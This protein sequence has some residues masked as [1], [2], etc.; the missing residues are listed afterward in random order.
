[1]KNLKTII[2]ILSTIF[3]LWVSIAQNNC[4]NSRFRIIWESEIKT[5]QVSEYTISDS[6][7]LSDTNNIK[8]NYTLWKENQR[9]ESAQW[10]KF[11]YNFEKEWEYFLKARFSIDWCTYNLEKKLDVFYKSILYIWYD[12]KEFEIWYENNF[13]N[14]AILFNKIIVSNNI[15]SENEIKNKILE[16]QNIIKNVNSIIINNKESD[17][18]FQ[19]LSKLSKSENIDLSNKE[20]FVINSTNKHFMKRILSKYIVN[21]KNKSTYLISEKNILNLLS[22]LS[23]WKNVLEESL[24]EISPLWFQE[25]SWRFF[26]SYLIDI[27]IANDFPINLIWFFLTITL[28][29]LFITWF[30]Q[31]IGFSVFWTFSPLLFG[32]SIAVLWTQASIIFFIIAFIA[33][34]LTRLITKNFYLLNSAKI[35]LLITIYL[36][37]IIILLWLDNHI[38]TNIL[39]NSI[40][41]NTFSIFPIIFLILVSDKVF[42]EW[43]KTFSK[44]RIV[45]LIEFILVSMIVYFTISSVRIKFILLSY[46]E[47]ILIIALFII[48]VW[49][50]TGLQVLEYFRFM[51]LLKSE[52]QEE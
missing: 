38:W 25:T 17:T 32:L 20:I 22:D 6:W 31:I 29:A 42:H 50:F 45:S 39:D 7:W 28:A 2:F 41:N 27:L 16:K 15:F 21:I 23:F 19:V 51:S 40:F 11:F 47:L 44:W 43:F 52:D 10:D 35:S 4:N 13:K 26:L 5:N 46:P 49:R 14:N 34:I 30:R 1:M 48:I 18:M 8:S 33:T 24:I 36:L 12:L 9:L 37:T 3:I